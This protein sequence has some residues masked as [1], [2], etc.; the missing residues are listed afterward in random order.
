MLINNCCV[1]INIFTA[2]ET[3]SKNGAQ[4]LPEE[5]QLR[6]FSYLRRMYGRLGTDFVVNR[7]DF[8]S[9]GG[10]QASHSQNPAPSKPIR[11]DTQ[12]REHQIK[13]FGKIKT[14][15]TDFAARLEVC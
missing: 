12:F 11:K 3:D 2:S 4:C 14:F 1:V 9:L 8:P 15:V 13:R 6:G 5:K 7:I 10:S